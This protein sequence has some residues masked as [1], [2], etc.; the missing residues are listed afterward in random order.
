M[1]NNQVTNNELVVNNQVMLYV[2][3]YIHVH[4]EKG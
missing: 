1:A 3:T 4:I 2:Y